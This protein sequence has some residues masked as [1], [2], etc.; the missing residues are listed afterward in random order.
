ME[1]A[2]VFTKVELPE[3]LAKKRV[4]LC[5]EDPFFISPQG[6]GSFAG[7]LSTWVRS[8]TCSLKCAWD[9]GNGT[10]T[11]CDTAYTSLYPQRNMIIIQDIY[12]NIMSNNAP[13][14]VLTGGEVSI[15]K[16][17]I[18]LI[19]YIEDSGKR[20]TVETNATKFFESKATLISMS[21]KL[22]SSSTGLKK[23]AEDGTTQDTG[24]FIP[25]LPNR[26][27]QKTQKQYAKF[28]E[29]HNKERYKPEELKKFIE[30]YGPDRYQF[31]FVVNTDECLNEI[32][33]NYVEL[34]Q[35]PNDNVWLM[36]QGCTHEE[37]Q[38]RAE[39]V[40]EQCK[41]FGFSYSDR[42]HVRIWGNKTGV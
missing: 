24:K 39:W 42:I 36:P 37:L 29:I 41:R 28:L 8:S 26:D 6:E 21:P 17:I 20:V 4:I 2:S 14:C 16:P 15:Q 13:H 7:R 9:N 40:V 5:K 22:L 38:T 19:D 11:L 27:W 3:D 10:V 31:K 12:D 1:G 18:D 34:L 30:Y 23:V 32:L 35:I 25:T 33:E